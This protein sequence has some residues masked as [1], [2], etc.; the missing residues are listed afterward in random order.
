[1]VVWSGRRAAGGLLPRASGIR[2]AGLLLG[3][4]HGGRV[5]LLGRRY[6]CRASKGPLSWLTVGHPPMLGF[7]VLPVIAGIRHRMGMIPWCVGLVQR[8]SRMYGALPLGLEGVCW[9]ALQGV[10]CRPGRGVVALLPAMV[11]VP[12]PLGRW[13]VMSS[14]VFLLLLRE[15]APTGVG[16]NEL[17]QVACRR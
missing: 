8:P 1:M 9:L 6:G 12:I 7:S 15:P 11:L 10:L 17:H 2:S 4:F 13:G 14:Q 5:I 16:P 3:P